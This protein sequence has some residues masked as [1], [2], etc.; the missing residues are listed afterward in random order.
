MRIC[1]VLSLVPGLLLS[2]LPIVIPFIGFT[3]G[4]GID[5][6]SIFTAG[7]NGIILALFVVVIGAGFTFLADKY[8][9]RR[10]GYAG[11]ALASSSGNSIANPAVIASID[12][13][14]KPFVQTATAEIASAVVLTAI[15]VPFIT[16]FVARKFGS[17]RNDGE[18][19]P[20]IA[21]DAE[22]TR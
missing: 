2:G 9:L 5:L 16:A 3:I 7:L 4:A 10:P 1:I 15:F 12:A 8:V 20:T 14:Y 6:G 22:V 21:E 18:H 19:L 13:T 17:G 11:A